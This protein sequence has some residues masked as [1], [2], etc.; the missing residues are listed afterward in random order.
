MYELDDKGPPEQ[1][2]YIDE[3]PVDNVCPPKPPSPQYEMTG[4]LGN[5]WSEL[6]AHFNI[7]LQFQITKE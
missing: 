2:K 7:F 1:I 6:Y 4:T 5:H 3:S